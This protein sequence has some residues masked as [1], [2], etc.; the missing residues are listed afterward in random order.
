M[1]IRTK[2]RFS[3]RDLGAGCNR[4]LMQHKQQA[5]KAMRAI[6]DTLIRETRKRVPFREGTL[7]ISITGDVEE[8]EKSLAATVYVPVNAPNKVSGEDQSMSYAVWM[9]EGEYDL[10]PGS[11][12]H[13]ART[14]E[15]V[16]PKYITRAITESSQKII[17]HLTKAMKL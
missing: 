5:I 14:G 13:Q 2:F 3:T 16:G 11:V 17:D 12:A 6:R 1:A 8:Y 9:H 15:K 4:C 10:G 7:H